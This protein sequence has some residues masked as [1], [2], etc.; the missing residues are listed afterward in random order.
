MQINALSPKEESKIC[1]D[2]GECC[3][4]YWITVLPSE[5]K[6]I[7]KKTKKSLKSFLENDCVILVK[8]YPKS[9]KGILTFPTAFFPKNI[10]D[11]IRT[12]VGDLPQS[13]FVVPQV[14]LKRVGNEQRA[15]T[16]LGEG[17]KCG[18]YKE[19]P[20]PC[21]LFP[22]IAVEGIRENYP[23][24]GLF[25]QTYKDL[26]KESQKYFKTVKKY[27]ATV[28]KKGFSTLWKTP[29]QKGYLYI[30]ETKVCEIT[31]NDLEKLMIAK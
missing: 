2:C 31:L 27:F 9:V 29:P 30:N 13:F 26:T 6:V 23:F 20:A 12:H 22:F 10:V 4:R 8:I 5:A 3:K 14:V 25:K 1:L 16:F 15:C 7:A 18:I 17:N 19:R 11:S 24:C 28:D 21:K